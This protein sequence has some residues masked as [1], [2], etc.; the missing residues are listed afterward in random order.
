MILF[1]SWLATYQWKK[2]LETAILLVQEL[3]IKKKQLVFGPTLAK[4]LPIFGEHKKGKLYVLKKVGL[5]T[6]KEMLQ[7]YVYNST[8]TSFNIILFCLKE[9]SEILNVGLAV[10]S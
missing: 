5:S 1:A 8:V 6:F 7:K 10:I 2:L 4:T 3:R 9:Y